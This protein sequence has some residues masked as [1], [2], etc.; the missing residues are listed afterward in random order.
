MAQVNRT[1]ILVA[2]S[3]AESSPLGNIWRITA[4]ETDFY[5]DPLGEAGA[6]HLSAHGPSVSN[7]GGHRFHVKA[8]ARAAAAIEE[9][10]DFIAYDLPRKGRP[11]DGQ[12]L[13][14]GV[15]RVARIRWLWHLQR[16]KY[17][18]AATLPGPV[19]EIAGNQS[20]RRLSGELGPNYAADIDLIVSYGKPHWPDGDRSI[21][22]NSR[23]GPLRNEAG[24][25]LT[26]TSYRRSLTKSPAPEG[27][28]GPLPKPGE[29]PTLILGGGPAADESGEMYWFVGAITSREVIEA[30]R[31]NA[32]A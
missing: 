14:P 26:A 21:R 31:G 23:L 18:A 2:F 24:M 13:A 10:G 32:A 15:F 1:E 11:F 28:D 29:Q 30:S 25:W 5:L 7:P 20:G 4:K 3:L 8:D 9:K 6:F 12:E 27:L 17:R 16:P 19:P 22:D